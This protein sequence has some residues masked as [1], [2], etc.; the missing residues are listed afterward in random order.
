MPDP[1]FTPAARRHAM[2]LARA[3]APFADPLERRFRALLRRRSLSDAAIRACLAIAPA[4][5][6]RCRSLRAFLEQVD[7]NGRRLAK[8]NIPPAEVKEI[9]REFG[10][11]LEARLGHAFPARART[12]VPGH[13]AHGGER[14][15]QRARGRGPGLLRTVSGGTGSPRPG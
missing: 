12:T 13:A 3:I 15:P 2:Q 1:F 10:K 7:Y 9:L 14:L 11:L 4:A 8:L 6:S 5:A